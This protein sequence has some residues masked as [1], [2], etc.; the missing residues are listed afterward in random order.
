MNFNG[1][2]IQRKKKE[3]LGERIGKWKRE[4]ESFWERSKEKE[5]ENEINGKEK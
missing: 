4:R 3:V 1:N 2:T 5:R